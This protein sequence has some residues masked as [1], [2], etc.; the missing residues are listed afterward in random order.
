MGRLSMYPKVCDKCGTKYS[1]RQSFHV[2]SK[3]GTCEKQTKMKSVT[4]NQNATTIINNNT[5][6]APNNADEVQLLQEQIKE[7][8][9]QNQIL[10]SS[11]KDPLPLSNERC[12]YIYVVRTKHASDLRVSVHKVGVT[13]QLKQRV[14]QYPCGAELMF[15]HKYEDAKKKEILL[16]KHLRSDDC[17]NIDA[18]LDFGSEFY[19][20]DIYYLIES[21]MNFMKDC[22][23]EK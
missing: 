20:C 1:N 3:N 17:N 12:G 7:L 6:N 10:T 2:H 13:A 19:E 9:I 22:K 21:I 5:Y 14:P 18:R 4:S 16:H 23:I 8:Q 11:S 15:C